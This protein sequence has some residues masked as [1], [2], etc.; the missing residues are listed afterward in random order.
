MQV[1][2]VSE[3]EET[4]KQFNDMYNKVINEKN[5]KYDENIDISCVKEDSENYKKE[6][7]VG[8]L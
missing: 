7:K 8:N 6:K 5:Y 1:V 2:T 4:I 3:N